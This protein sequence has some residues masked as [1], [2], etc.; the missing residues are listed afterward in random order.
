MHEQSPAASR[1]MSRAH[2]QRS[3]EV[4]VTREI[5]EPFYAH[6][7]QRVERIDTS[8]VMRGGSCS[9]QQYGT[10]PAWDTAAWLSEQIFDSRQL[11]VPAKNVRSVNKL[12]L[13]HAFENT[14]LSVMSEGLSAQ[15]CFPLHMARDIASAAEQEGVP[16][17]EGNSLAEISR[18]MQRRDI[19][20]M[21]YTAAFTANGVWGNYSTSHYEPFP[22]MADTPLLKFVFSAEGE[23]DFSD[24]FKKY[25][26]ERMVRV[27]KDGKSVETALGVQFATS[28]GCPA[29]RTRAHFND[30][31]AD[32]E[33]LAILSTYFGKSPEALLATHS[34]NIITGGLDTLTS[35]LDA[36]HSRLEA[37]KPRPTISEKYT[38]RLGRATTYLCTLAAD[39]IKGYE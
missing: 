13:P 9:L 2:T 6:C 33:R 35:V 32:K 26:R 20:G 29:L 18:I 10:V 27:N 22:Y 17:F 28:S 1:D 21:I 31:D 14:V 37:A 5:I 8:S 16:G 15:A 7:A 39:V 34:E 24:D 30:S 11:F 38:E 25:L 12:L 19:R 3:V 36:M 23:V 4:V